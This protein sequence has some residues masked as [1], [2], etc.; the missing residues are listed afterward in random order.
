M[1]YSMVSISKKTIRGKTY[2]YA[3]ECRRVDGKP[4]IVWQKYLG[5]AEDIVAAL[6]QPRV[7]SPASAVV[8]EFGAVTALFDLAQRLRL[9]E[10][11]DRH[12][13]ARRGPSG[14]SVGTY[15]LVAAL[16]RCVEPRSKAQIATWFDRTVLR[17]LLDIHPEQL[18]SQRFWDQMDRVSAAA[19]VAIERDLT[20]HL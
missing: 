3:R 8:T 9:V 13:P 6:G 20:T 19:I 14:P 7:V 5:K 17:R 2:Y 18:S 1:T 10:H 12:V 15:L 11:I 4:K 16:N